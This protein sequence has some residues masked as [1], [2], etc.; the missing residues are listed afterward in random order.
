MQRL[1]NGTM[2]GTPAEMIEYERLQKGDR[3]KFRTP[4]DRLERLKIIE[5]HNRKNFLTPWVLSD[6]GERVLVTTLTDTGYAKHKL[7]QSIFGE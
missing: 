7:D 5:E 1:A 2:T 6:N 3:L 4:L